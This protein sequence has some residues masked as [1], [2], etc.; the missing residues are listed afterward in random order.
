MEYVVD[1][2]PDV[3]EHDQSIGLFDT[4][5][6]LEL[7]LSE[8]WAVGAILPLRSAFLGITYRDQNGAPV[9]ILDADV[10]HRNETLVGPG[11]PWVWARWSG[12]IQ[13]VR[14]GAR[15]G[16]TLPVGRTEENPFVLGSL[17][18]QHQHLQFGTGTVDVLA[19]V[20]A[21]WKAD[22]WRLFGWGLTRQVLAP[23]L[24]GY[25]AGDV[26]NLAVLGASGFGLKR[27][28]VQ[29]GLTLQVE[30]AERWTQTATTREGNQ[31]RTDFNFLT[32]ATF[33]ITDETW[34]SA[35]V[36]LPLVVATR[37]AQLRFPVIG[38]LS[39]GG[40]LDFGE[41]SGHDHGGT[42]S[43]AHGCG[44]DE[45]GCGEDEGAEA[46]ADHDEGDAHDHGHD[47][48]DHGEATSVP[49]P[50][51]VDVQDAGAPGEAVELLP[52]PGMWTVYDFWATW[53][54]P[55][56]VLGV[57]L[58]EFAAAHP[59]QV[60]IRKVDIVDDETDA[61]RVHLVPGD[62]DLPHVKLVHPDGRVV[63]ELSGGPDDIIEA[64]R[65]AIEGVE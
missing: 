49:V 19:G 27:F 37:G 58:I 63:L 38:S 14:V 21:S 4:R 8:Q 54:A 28:D 22:G 15:F 6:N 23:N 50:E 17:E 55:C 25:Q 7:G 40:Y 62:H 20:Q 59:G 36:Q 57:K 9:E 29:A 52:V 43:Q 47:D 34:I 13:K 31:G 33:S 16:V 2:G 61:T 12:A 39:I 35:Q 46:H 60:A 42:E 1:Q 10:H 56:K 26:Y 24:K 11:D 32:G 65:E 41:E 3:V 30:T 53:C 64:L 51:G 18:E 45:H 48:G 44:A 5:L